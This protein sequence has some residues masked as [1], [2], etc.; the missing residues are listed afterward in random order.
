MPA[1]MQQELQRKTLLNGHFTA[2]GKIYNTKMTVK[3]AFSM[4]QGY[5]I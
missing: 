1:I 3:K 5:Q 4:K 2:P